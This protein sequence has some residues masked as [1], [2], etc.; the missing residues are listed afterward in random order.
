METR[1]HF[2]NRVNPKNQMSR[3]TNKRNYE[4]V[5]KSFETVR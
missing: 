1:S 3:K 5:F 2:K 4:L